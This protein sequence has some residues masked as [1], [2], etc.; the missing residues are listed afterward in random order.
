MITYQDMLSAIGEDDTRQER[1]LMDFCKKVIRQ[2][3][4]SE[5]YKTA[6][7]ADEYY[8]QM[9]RTITRFQKILYTMSGEAV[10]D[11]FGACYRIPSRFFNRFVTQETQ[12]LLGNGVTWDGEDNPL[13]D[14]FD[15]QL[16]K[17][18]KKALCGAVA[19]GFYNLD[20]AE[21]FSILEF[22]PIYDE[23]NGALRAGVRFWQVDQTKPM[24]AT[25]YEED[26]YTEIIWRRKTRGEILQPKRK[27]KL[28]IRESEADGMEIYD[29][30]NYPTFPIVPLWANEQH[31][32]EI[33]GIR[34]GIDAYDL[35]KSGAA[36]DI[37]EAAQI[38]WIIQNASEMDDVDL[39]KF[40]E[41]LKVVKAATVDEDGAVA[42][43][44]TIDIPF[45]ARESILTR[46][47]KDLYKDFMALDTENIASGAVT[48]ATQ[49]RAAYEP[50]NNKV[51]EF[52]HCVDQFIDGLLRVAGKDVKYT[53]ERS[54]NINVQETVQTVMQAADHLSSDYVTR[55]VLT[56]FGDGDLANDML[57]ELDAEDMQKINLPPRE[58]EEWTE[59]MSL[60]T[61]E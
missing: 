9:N 38:Y 5:I 37:D 48:T 3:Q 45:E 18:G 15:Y 14:D 47:E 11:L 50:L 17:A 30:E 58:G 60:Q 56:A 42:E 20:H 57:K 35:I 10:P 29:G 4:A 51:D 41:R 8:R 12:Y 40:I 36:S 61:N 31:Q 28:I 39:R 49:I 21:V 16:Q 27:Y 7:I 34:E 53:F 33:V 6:Q 24:R 52:E 46:I 23:E 25:L 55:K 2:H 26:G 54:M 43:P 59:G 19:F 44:H 13:G 22:A 1:E 32:S